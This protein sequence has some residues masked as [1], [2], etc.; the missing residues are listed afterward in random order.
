MGPSYYSH[1]SHTFTRHVMSVCRVMCVR[2]F[3]GHFFF[4]FLFE[5]LP[6]FFF[7]CY[8]MPSQNEHIMMHNFVS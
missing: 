4:L 3:L 1:F 2:E 6:A 5:L 7:V 8:N